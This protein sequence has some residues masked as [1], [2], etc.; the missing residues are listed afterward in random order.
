[1]TIPEY[2]VVTL[3]ASGKGVRSYR[4]IYGTVRPAGFVAGS[5]ECGFQ[6]NSPLRL[7]AVGFPRQSGY[8]RPLSVCQY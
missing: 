1:L 3:M 2:K 5:C 6:N 8:L 7:G 4:A